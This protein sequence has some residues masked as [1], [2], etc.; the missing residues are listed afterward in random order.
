MSRI[1]KKP[2]EIPKG[3]EVKIEGNIVT[4][5][6]PKGS[7]TK[8]FHKDMQILQEDGKIIVKRPS[9]DKNHKALHGL[10]RSLLANMV[11]GVVNGYE[12]SL[13][14]EGVGYR[15]SKQ[16]NKLVLT[17]G[18][19]HPVEIEAPKGI[20]FEVPAQNKIIVRGIDKEL[21]GITAANIR[22][23]KEPEPYKG[24]GIRYENEV[25]RRKVGK[26]GAK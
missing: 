24:K 20:E 15:A 11:N 23:V 25:V 17:V 10:T 5:K 8:E 13:M 7:I 1:G 21:V 14:L 3:V 9:D 19:S 22:K 12:K 26:A 16:G 2:I 6:G 18:F 4:I